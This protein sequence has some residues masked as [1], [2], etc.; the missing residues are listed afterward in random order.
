MT[1]GIYSQAPKRSASSRSTTPKAP[2]R[3]SV[4][5][6]G[7]TLWNNLNMGRKYTT[8]MGFI[9]YG[10][11]WNWGFCRETSDNRWLTCIDVR[12]SLH[13]FDAQASPR[14]S[15]STQTGVMPVWLYVL[16]RI[17]IL[18]FVN[19]PVT[20]RGIKLGMKLLIVHGERSLSFIFIYFYQVG[21]CWG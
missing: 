9:T 19:G 16:G 5:H 13:P 15:S 4:V 6:W 12:V 1:W 17:L 7:C 20:K 21:G 18:V 14:S 10:I 11:V 8:I 2:R 3:G